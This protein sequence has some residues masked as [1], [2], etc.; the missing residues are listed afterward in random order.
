M[1]RESGLVAR[2]V[3]A[4]LVRPSVLGTLGL[5]TGVIIP[6]GW[7]EQGP[8]IC[9]FKL[10]TGM[11]CPGCGLTRSVVALLHGDLTTSLHFHPLGVLFVLLVLVLAIVDGWVW[12]RAKRPGAPVRPPSWLLERL[13]VT[14][15][16]WVAV[17]V[18]MLVWAVRLPLYVVGAWV[19]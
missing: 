9:M 12:W 4:Q 7:I 14:P 2:R 17:A 19:Y 18:L 8:P 6:F 1:M 3:S 11:P 13:A 5:F 10:M 16:P 15:A